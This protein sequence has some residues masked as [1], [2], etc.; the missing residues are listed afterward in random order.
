MGGSSLEVDRSRCDIYLNAISTRC[1]FCLLSVP[2]TLTFF[3]MGVSF[4]RVLALCLCLTLFS[5][6]HA[7]AI[8]SFYTIQG[9]TIILQNATTGQLMYNI[10]NGTA[11]YGDFRPI[12]TTAGIPPKNG[13]SLACTGYQ[14][15][16]S[17]YVSLL[18]D[19]AYIHYNN[20]LQQAN[21]Q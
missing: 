18:S 8:T 5:A 3:T 21:N 11:G 19:H 10:Y 17:L 1:V 15:G 7:Q 9:P 16:P 6:A 20:P 13:T 4:H 2:H 14:V 12:N